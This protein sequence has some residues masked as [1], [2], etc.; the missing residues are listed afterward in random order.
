MTDPVVPG[1]LAA[2]Q[3][4]YGER[5]RWLLLLSLMIGTMASV[6]SST[7]V[8]VAIPD[9]SQ[10][11]ALGQDRAH[12]VSSGF[13]A[14]MTLS[15]LPTS[16][17][18]ARFGYRHTYVGAVTLLM[19]G[20][21]FGGLARHYELVLAMRVAE[22]L[23]AGVLQVIPSIIVLRAFGD[24][25]RGRA[26]G[27][28]GF[29]VVLAPAIGPTVGG[30]L[31]EHFG[32]RSIFFVVVPFALWAMLLA[33][34]YLP[35]SAPGGA[36]PGEH[37]SPLDWVGLALAAVGVIGLL[38]GLVHL[39]DAAPWSA[40]VHLGVGVTALGLFVWHAART[41][42][43][44]FELGL[45]RSR[46][47]AM[48]SVVAFVYGMGLFGS[49]YLLPVFMLVALKLSASSVGAV[50][51]PAGLALALTIP[52]AGKL[53]DHRPLAQTIV[54][55]LS[56]MCASFAAVLAVGEHT[57]VLWVTLIAVL[58]RIGLGLVIPSLSLASV[59]ALPAPLMPYGTSTMNF[60]RQLGGAIGVSAVGILL[61]WRLQAHGAEA[62]GTLAAFH[63]VFVLM[64]LITGLAALAARRMR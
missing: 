64:A 34:R 44:L 1:S 29:G 35:V 3:A 37:S 5:H 30:V 14:A 53:S 17:L 59:R 55:G 24:G 19:L 50:L 32:W 49:T 38:N 7:I 6:M 28:F 41:P 42:T 46:P 16:W 10:H 61:E 2:L 58:G 60:L 62:G 11:F 48:G 4:R 36:E 15:M 57:A 31:V 63:E 52:V 51:L 25:E 27:I 47:F 20:G 26:M 8:N 18:L 9:M 45:F 43:P 13:M 22:G 21:I 12:W 56:V 39:H 40:A 54:I 23:A 33:R